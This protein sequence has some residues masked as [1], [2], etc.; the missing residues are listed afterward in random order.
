MYIIRFLNE[1]KLSE[2]FDQFNDIDTETYL[3]KLFS[4]ISYVR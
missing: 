3:F 2:I 4:K 1:E